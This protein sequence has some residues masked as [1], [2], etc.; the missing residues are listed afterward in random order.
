MRSEKKLEQIV[1]DVMALLQLGIRNTADDQGHRLTGKLQKSTVFDVVKTAD[2]Y[3]GSM[4]ME[5]YGTYVEFGVKA[6]RIPYGGKRTGAKTSKYIQGLIT[7]WKRR[8]LSER[9]SKDA[10]FATARKHKRE[11]MPTRASSRFS[12]TGERTGFISKSIKEATPDIITLIQQR[13]GLVLQLQFGEM[14]A[15]LDNITMQ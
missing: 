15:G 5:E 6:E 12:R 9:D 8:G 14:L 7:Y 11:G 3:K 2:G 4:Y 13:Y 1:V 10:A